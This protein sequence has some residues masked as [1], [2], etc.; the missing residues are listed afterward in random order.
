MVTNSFHM[1]RTQDIFQHCFA[2]GSAAC[3]QAFGLS[4][5]AVSDEGLF[6]AAAL[7]A[8]QAKEL[9]ALQVHV[10]L[11]LVLHVLGHA[12][13]LSSW[14][15]ARSAGSRT[16]RTSRRLQAC[17]PGCS[18]HTCA[19]QSL[20]RHAPPLCPQ[21]ELQPRCSQPAYAGMLA[22][23]CKAVRL[24]VAWVHTGRARQP[25]TW[26][27]HVNAGRSDLLTPQSSLLSVPSQ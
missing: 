2:L 17:T 5:H 3:K 16:S 24:R 1:P 23:T 25:Q 14:G 26:A 4:F 10:C 6:E 8:R 9:Q 27:V 19:M 11:H 13:E 7:E 12:S 18:A 21:A 22:S 20:D 15:L